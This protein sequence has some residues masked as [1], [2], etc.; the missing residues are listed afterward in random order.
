MPS[1]AW[2]TGTSDCIRTFIIH[3]LQGILTGLNERFLLFSEEQFWTQMYNTKLFVFAYIPIP[4]LPFI[5]FLSPFSFFFFPPIFVFVA[6][7]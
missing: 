1:V 3:I 2:G 4:H 7:C 6:F 5:F